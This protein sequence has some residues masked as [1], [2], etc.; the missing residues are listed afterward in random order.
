MGLLEALM[1]CMLYLAIAMLGYA[2]AGAIIFAIVYP[3]VWL[4]EKIIKIVTR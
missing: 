3:L 1:M 2:L 4:I